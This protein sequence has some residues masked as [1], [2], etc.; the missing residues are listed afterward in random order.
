MEDYSN[1]WKFVIGVLSKYC[2]PN[3]KPNYLLFR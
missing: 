3:Y 1:I 2:K